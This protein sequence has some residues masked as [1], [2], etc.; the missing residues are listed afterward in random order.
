MTD[1]NLTEIDTTESLGYKARFNN[2]LDNLNSKKNND[3]SKDINKGKIMG[4][5]NIKASSLNNSIDK[6]Y[7]DSRSN[8]ISNYMKIKNKMRKQNG[9]PGYPG[10][11]Y[12]F[13]SD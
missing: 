11:P 7:Y 3:N 1:N 13:L 12:C 8:K 5:S 2:Y 9:L 6:Y 4:I 10:S